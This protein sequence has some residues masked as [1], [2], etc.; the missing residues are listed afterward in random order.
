MRGEA[1]EQLH[2][3]LG[4]GGA[5]LGDDVV[6]AELVGGDDVHVALDDDGAA[7]AA[8][9][10]G[11]L[12]ERVEGAALV[13]EGGLGGVQVLR[14]RVVEGARAEA[15]DPAFGVPD[16]EHQAAPEA[17]VEAVV[18]L[19]E[20]SGVEHLAVAEAL[21]FQVLAGVLPGA[22]AVTEAELALSGGVEAALFEIAGGDVPA[23]VA[24]SGGK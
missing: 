10:V 24:S 11:G 13:E 9:A 6:E 1:L 23:S 2:L 7:F 17:V 18:A 14:H 19:H 5:H 21:R 8:D 22:E 20:E 4:E 15:D 3:A 16:G 12:V